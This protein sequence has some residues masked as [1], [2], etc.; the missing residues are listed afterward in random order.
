MAAIQ[1]LQAALEAGSNKQNGNSSPHDSS[2]ATRLDTHE[3]RWANQ[4]PKIGNFGH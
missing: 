1:G 2:A 3:K 4:S